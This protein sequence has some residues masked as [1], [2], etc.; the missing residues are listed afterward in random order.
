MEV[1]EA[2]RTDGSRV[3]GWHNPA[4]RKQPRLLQPSTL[5]NVNPGTALREFLSFIQYDIEKFHI[6]VKIPVCLSVVSPIEERLT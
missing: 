1:K 5:P 2:F 3:D 6:G 4:A